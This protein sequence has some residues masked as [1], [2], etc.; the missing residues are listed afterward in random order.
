[1]G[2]LGPSVGCSGCLIVL[3]AAVAVVV[4]LPAGALA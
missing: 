1:M 2:C 4:A 3:V